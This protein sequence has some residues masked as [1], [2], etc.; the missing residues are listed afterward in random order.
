MKAYT[1]YRIDYVRHESEPVGMMLE[2]RRIYRGNNFEGLLKQ[3]QK[4]FSTLSQKSQIT[5]SPE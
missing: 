3:A 5:L 4:I 1:V 2:R